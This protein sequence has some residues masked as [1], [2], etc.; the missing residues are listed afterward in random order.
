MLENPQGQKTIMHLLTNKHVE[1]IAASAVLIGGLAHKIPASTTD[2]LALALNDDLGM[3][4][5]T[6]VACHA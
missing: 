4:I 6:Q 5:N 3:H 1:H 2:L